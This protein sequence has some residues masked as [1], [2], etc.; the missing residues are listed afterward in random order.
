MSKLVR[1]TR[2]RLGPLLLGAFALM[3]VL[4]GLLTPAQTGRVQA[5]VP[6]PTDTATVTVTRTPT[7]TATRT[8]TG[9]ST[10]SPTPTRTPTQTATSTVTG[11][12]THT[13][14]PTPTSTATSSSAAT[15]TNT[16]TITPT[17]T[18]TATSAA[19]TATAAATATSRSGAC[20]RVTGSPES[21]WR[22]AWDCLNSV[23]SA[24]AS[25]SNKL[26]SGGRVTNESTTSATFV[27]GNSDRTTTSPAATPPAGSR[28][29]ARGNSEV[30]RR[31]EV[32]NSRYDKQ[33]NAPNPSR[34]GWQRKAR[35]TPAPQ[36][37]AFGPLTMKDGTSMGDPSLYSDLREQG[38]ETLAGVPGNGH[39]HKLVGEINMAAMARAGQASADLQARYA[40]GSGTLTVWVGQEDGLIYKT[41]LRVEY[42]GSSG[43]GGATMVQESAI[44][45]S[46]HNG[47]HS[48]VAPR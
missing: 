36:S 1:S 20:G 4:S 45:I 44:T 22:D 38:V 28:A 12:A 26:T 48:V 5:Q 9:T 16:A 3:V 23:S 35:P 15:A 34:A 14:T 27:R 11:T 43:S 29:R 46:E 41:E 33:E 2:R 21:R 37:G 25:A 24:K 8:A 13:A 10:P 39:V 7:G 18:P 6:P 30:R 47:N 32:D 31:V 19:S 42:P 40:R 17:R